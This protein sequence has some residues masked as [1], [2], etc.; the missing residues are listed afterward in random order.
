F[1]IQAIQMNGNYVVWQKLVFSKTRDGRAIQPIGVDVFLHDVAAAT[2]TKIPSAEDVWQ[3]G[4]SVDAEGTIYFGRSTSECDE[5]AQMIER[6][7]DGTESVIHT[8]AH[9]R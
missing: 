7:I 1:D 8:F 3:Y 6:Q 4:P 2:T 9:R 5:N